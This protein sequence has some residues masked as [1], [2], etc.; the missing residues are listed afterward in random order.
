MKIIIDPAQSSTSTLEIIT[1]VLYEY[2]R[3]RG[4]R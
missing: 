3:K 4:S 2:L 1:K